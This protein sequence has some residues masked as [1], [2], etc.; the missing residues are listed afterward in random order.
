MSDTG[1]V[2]YEIVKV[3]ESFACDRIVDPPNLS[4]FFFFLIKQHG[5]F[6]DDCL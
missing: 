5:Y 1:R 3:R 4:I 6:C 2:I